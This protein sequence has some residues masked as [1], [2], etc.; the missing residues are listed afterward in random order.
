MNFMVQLEIFP[1]MVYENCVLNHFCEGLSMKEKLRKKYLWII[2][3]LLLSLVAGKSAYGF[4]PGAFGRMEA[5]AMKKIDKMSVSQREKTRLRREVKDTLKQ[6][7]QEHQ[8]ATEAVKR[9]Q[10]YVDAGGVV[11]ESFKQYLDTSGK[12]LGMM[13]DGALVTDTLTR[14]EQ[15]GNDMYLPEEAKGTA[16]ALTALG[17]VMQKA[18]DELNK[19]LPGIG[20]AMTGYGQ[21][22]QKLAGMTSDIAKGRTKQVEGYFQ[23]I[24]GGSAEDKLMDDVGA[25]G[26]ARQLDLWDGGIPLVRADLGGQ[27]DKYF[28]KVGDT[29]EEIKDLKELKKI[30]GD[31]R[32]TH[33]G[34]NPDAK[35]VQTL[36]N[37]G[38]VEEKYVT[39]DKKELDWTAQARVEAAVQEGLLRKSIGDSEFEKLSSKERRDLRD[40]LHVFQREIENLGGVV[41]EDRLAKLFN[42]GVIQGNKDRILKNIVYEQDPEGFDQVLEN[43]GMTLDDIQNPFELQDMVMPEEQQVGEPS[44]ETTTPE[45]KIDGGDLG[46]KGGSGGGF[47]FFKTL[48]EEGKMDNA[49]VKPEKEAWEPRSYVLLR[50]ETKDFQ[51]R[52]KKLKKRIQEN[53]KKVKKQIQEL[54]KER[55]NAISGRKKQQKQTIVRQ[56]SSTYNPNKI[57]Y[58]G[59]E[60]DDTLEV[61]DVQRQE[62]LVKN[63]SAYKLRQLVTDGYQSLSDGVVASV[64]K[65]GPFNAE[66]SYTQ[67]FA[68]QAEPGV[69]QVTS[70]YVYEGKPLGMST[71]FYRY[72]S[73]DMTPQEFLG[74][75]TTPGMDLDDIGNSYYVINDKGQLIKKGW[76]YKTK[77]YLN[78]V[79][80][81]EIENPAILAEKTAQDRKINA[82]YDWLIEFN[83]NARERELENLRNTYA[84][85]ERELQD[86]LNILEDRLAVMDG[87]SDSARS[88][89]DY[90]YRQLKDPDV[91]EVYDIM[92]EFNDIQDIEE[93]PAISVTVNTKE[94][95]DKIFGKPAKVPDQ[96]WNTPEAPTIDRAKDLAPTVQ[97]AAPQQPVQQGDHHQ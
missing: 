38:I 56:Y 9:T 41:D 11:P 17:G 69:A 15:L 54:R 66:G 81:I 40:Q 63:E 36:L 49:T 12:M 71:K 95:W 53:V 85:R 31:W 14:M 2:P 33:N 87:K 7:A 18:G 44:K 51:Q 20:D 48:R 90:S 96:Q 45:A 4:L 1:R 94:E 5:E 42:N 8:Y 34:T 88:G 70:F 39:W 79:M 43:E 26:L 74:F 35:S 24:R 22:A 58:E 6:A 19:I 3:A 65:K 52:K 46:T 29:Y 25:D 27:Q 67:Y 37:G 64:K 75:V 93:N 86:Q 73:N 97:P 76:D 50:N 57:V 47:S 55:D 62:K 78:R 82:E 21:V 13:G 89:K 16:Q 84:M 80:D 72:N 91:K 83:R 61:L 68:T 32:V 92:G 60:Y 59:K 30:V 77:R 28:L 10:V 23:N